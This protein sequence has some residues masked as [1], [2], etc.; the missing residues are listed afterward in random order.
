MVHD[1]SPICSM[2]ASEINLQTVLSFHPEVG[3]LLLNDSRMLIFSQHSLRTLQ[4]ILVKH[5]GHEYTKALFA[6]FGYTCGKHDYLNIGASDLW[7][8]DMD[9]IASG[10]VM[11]MWEGIVHVEPTKIEFDRKIDHFHMTGL[12]RNSYEAENYLAEFGKSE[13]PV[14][15]SL[16]GYASGWATAF[17]G[18]EL[19][20]IETTCIAK[21]DPHCAF[22]IR[23][24]SKWGEEAEL[25]RNALN[26]TS[27]SVSHLLEEQVRERTAKL[28]IINQELEQAVQKAEQANKT[29]GQFLANISHEL[30]T[31]MNGVIGLAQLLVDTDLDEKQRELLNLIIESGNQQVDI[32]SDLLD[33][34][35]IESGKMTLEIKNFSFFKI[36]NGIINNFTNQCKLKNL[37][38][39]VELDKSLPDQ[40]LGDELKIHQIIVNLLGNAVKFTPV[41]GHVRISAWVSDGQIR[42]TVKDSGI[43]ISAENITNL[44][45][46]FV[47]ADLSTTRKYGGTGLGL[48]ITREL[49]LLF[50]GSISVKSEEGKGSRFTISFPF[51][52]KEEPDEKEK[53]DRIHNLETNHE[54][55]KDLPLSVLI[56]EDN[57]INAL[58]IERML[59]KLGCA[60]EI[61]VNGKDAFEKFKTN[62]PDLVFLDL[63]MPVM[64]GWEAIQ[65]FRAYEIKNN[66][67]P[68][69]IYALTAD[70]YSSTREKCFKEG[71]DGFFTKPIN[72]N[73]IRSLINILRSRLLDRQK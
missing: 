37:K 7:D 42:M 54:L 14:C 72:L 29:K 39:T 11:H 33:F 22:E 58:V 36:L 66:L 1:G 19:L 44:F 34:S 8:S 43:G 6:Q 9:R 60:P 51:K 17:Y 28:E 49:L 24:L 55:G 16:T 53:T 52:T 12:W 67:G 61:T 26:A 46:P 47:Q 21:G 5:F 73:E 30:R 65:A 70:A 56:A 10:P 48:A 15:A 41:G 63:H 4:T 27:S 71:F 64:D 31:P 18:K 3:K 35:K 50:G 69:S 57:S 45:E 20:A 32:I 59:M 68:C 13:C 62:Y 2:K 38:L 25:W 23:P 40:I